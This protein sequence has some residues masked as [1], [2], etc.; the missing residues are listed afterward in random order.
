MR[1]DR[2]LLE[3]FAPD[4][5]DAALEDLRVERERR[6]RGGS[7]R[8]R[9]TLGY[10]VQLVGV[11]FYGVRDRLSPTGSSRGRPGTTLRGLLRPWT[12]LRLAFRGL[13]RRPG[14]A[15][16]A[17]LTL[18]LG[19]G[20]AVGLLGVAHGTFRPLPVPD[21][22]RVVRVELRDHRAKP[23]SAPPRFL[24]AVSRE[25]G[26]LDALGAV[27][28]FD[29]DLRGPDG[30]ALR[31]S[32]ARMTPEVFDLLQVRP[33]RGRTF[34]RGESDVA[35]VGHGMWQDLLGG[36]QDVIGST[37]RV[38]GRSR[39]VIG[40]MPD[41]F[42]F[43]FNQSL[44]LPFHARSAEDGFAGGLAGAE[45]VGRLAPRVTFEEAAAELEGTLAGLPGAGREG[46]PRR[47]AVRPWGGGR[48]EADEG[49]A[50]AGLG[51]LVAIL[52][53][54]AA[55]NVSTLLLVRAVE[56]ADTLAVHAAL[57]ASRLQVAVQLMA[58]SVLVALAGGGLGL[59]LGH[60]LLTWIE[61]TLSVH[62]GY[63]WMKMEIR[64]AVVAWTL[65]LVLGTA[66]LA[67]TAPAFRAMRADLQ[68][69][70]KSERA[71]RAGARGLGGWFAGVQ[72]ALS[73]VALVAA[74]LLALGVLRASD[75]AAGLPLDE[76]T[77]AT[78]APDSAL[79]PDADAR[80]T[81]AVDLAEAVRT[82]LPGAPVTLSTGMPVFGGARATLE[83][84]GRP[85]DGGTERAVWLGADP[86]YFRVYDLPLRR[87]RLL[88]ESDGPS[89]LR[90]AVV[91][92]SFV[93]RFLAG[94]EPVVMPLSLAGVPGQDGPVTVVGVVADAL[95]DRPGSRSDRVYL[96]L[97]Q[98]DAGRLLL[99]V[100]GATP[101]S[102]APR[103]R[104]AARAVDPGLPVQDIR[105]LRDF[106]AYLSR[107]PRTLGALGALGGVAGV[108]V[109]AI[110]L[111]GLLAFQVRTRFPEIGVRMA[112][113][114]P[115]RRI[116]LQILGEGVRRMA[117]GLAAGMALGALLSPLLVTYLFGL[118][119]SLLLVYGGVLATML[120]VG[121]LASLAPALR[122]ARLD[123]LTVLRSE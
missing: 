121:F 12:A 17:V 34:R 47:V 46:A 22:E 89:T 86:S 31:R 53:V 80:R 111:Y 72:V 19:L 4:D 90:V 43:P 41:G 11:C 97:E 93:R 104:E 118:S 116:L 59:L 39:T 52:L 85:Q 5:A 37:L 88:Q 29:A 45:L 50:L 36:G 3:W 92:E 103:L 99:S 10:W 74:V 112:L 73:T 105:S 76:V 84:P 2:R 7:G 33:V 14:T 61:A 115:S 69:A 77:V 91:N 63:Y 35:V 95:P 78:V 109:A 114:A 26:S 87:G 108:L 32:G 23:V 100:R 42:G 81:L 83:V 20:A 56:R 30:Y 75:T 21:G 49:V 24:E 9:P 25:A 1:L 102:A 96:P 6:L 107:M 119:P 38:D 65:L 15:I 122:A 98:I 51:V 27:R 79:T 113:G 57:G 94:R 82:R 117:P 64:P 66:V 13:V 60:G 8:L 68:R 48:G 110:G 55:A 58:E 40:V 18:G 106:V 70:L 123:P 101:A 16:A 62:W 28:V 44:W 71:G 120:G 67:G 54:I